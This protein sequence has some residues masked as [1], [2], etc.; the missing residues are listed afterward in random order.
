MN[1]S[2]ISRISREKPGIRY[3][4]RGA[5][6]DGNVSNFV[7]TEQILQTSND[8][9][10]FLQIRGSIPLLWEQRADGCYKPL[11]N[12]G[13]REASKEALTK[14]MNILISRYNQVSVVNLVDKKGHESLLGQEY[15]DILSSYECAK[16]KYFPF[17]LHSH[18]TKHKWKN[19]SIFTDK[20]SDT[21]NQYSYYRMSNNEVLSEQTGV[22]RTNCIDCIDRTN[23]IQRE[24]ARKSLLSQL[25]SAHVIEDKQGLSEYLE[26]FHKKGNFFFFF[27]FNVRSLLIIYSY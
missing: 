24:I 27:F 11:I 10:S 6:I 23:M 16:L 5:D 15:D 19:M 2:L 26:Y 13:S 4:S 14:H 8:T 21:L 7:E 22:F 9:F 1:V 20:I 3:H 18:C 12:I 17:D 25:K